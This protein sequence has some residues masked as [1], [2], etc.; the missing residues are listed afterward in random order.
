MRAR[1][2]VAALCGCVL[3]VPSFALADSPA[4]RPH[5]INARQD[6]QVDRIKHGVRADDINRRELTRLRAEE[7]R[8]RAE[9][10]RYRESGNGLNTREFRDLQRDLTR[11]SHD[12]HRATHN[13]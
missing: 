9:E 4:Q 10:R 7:A 5:G 13:Q 2:A 1:I 6:R 11:I 8:L 3:G 12:I